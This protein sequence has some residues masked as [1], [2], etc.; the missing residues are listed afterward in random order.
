MLLYFSG[1]FGIFEHIRHFAQMTSDRLGELFSCPACCSTW[2][3]FFLS[4]L[5]ILIIPTIPFT[6]FNLILGSTDLWWLI[7]ML[8]GLC[9]SGTTWLLF[10][11]EDY[12]VSNTEGEEEDEEG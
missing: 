9:G 1:P 4:A 8:D 10:K 5:N 2:V 7:I 3:S 11:F 6:P 12:L